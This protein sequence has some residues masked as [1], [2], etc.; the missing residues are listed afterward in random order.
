MRRIETIYKALKEGK[1]LSPKHLNYIRKFVKQVKDY[2]SSLIK[3]LRTGEKVK[4]F[5]LTEGWGEEKER[6]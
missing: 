2:E 3:R 1:D 4:G 5:K 6:E